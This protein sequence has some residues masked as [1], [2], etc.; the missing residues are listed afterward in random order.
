M[1]TKRNNN[2]SQIGSARVFDIGC[3]T[4][5]PFT[6]NGDDCVA[7]GIN[8]FGGTV[9]VVAKQ[10]DPALLKMRA[11]ME[12]SERGIVSVISLRGFAITERSALTTI[13]EQSGRQPEIALRGIHSV[14]Y[15]DKNRTRSESK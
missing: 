9:A 15:Y 14:T 7:L 6:P 10:N 13:A 1:D 4:E 3:I 5:Q 8:T 2:Y 11:E 12:R